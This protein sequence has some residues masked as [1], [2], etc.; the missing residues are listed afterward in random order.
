MSGKTGRSQDKRKTEMASGF[1]PNGGDD[2]AAFVA[3]L[4][5]KIEAY[6]RQVDEL[7][8][9]I[10]GL[11]KL[12]QTYTE[13]ADAPTSNTAVEIPTNFARRKRERK[14][15]KAYIVRRQAFSILMEAGR[16]LDRAEL[17]DAF[18][19]R[20]IIIDGPNPAKLVGKILWEAPEFEHSED[21]YWIAGQPLPV[22]GTAGTTRRLTE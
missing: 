4:V 12:H 16:P 8:R 3:Q 10:S 5:D 6:Q 19:Q 17:F 7:Q 2:D 14:E 21:G 11:R 15:S 20:G 22:A 13:H 9:K 1:Q 18:K